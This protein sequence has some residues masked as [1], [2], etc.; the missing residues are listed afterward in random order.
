MSAFRELRGILAGLSIGLLVGWM[1]WGLEGPVRSGWAEGPRDTETLLVIV[2]DG[3]GSLDVVR[4]AVSSDRI[5]ASS[6]AGLAIAPQRLVVTALEAAGPLLTRAGWQDR[7]MEIFDLGRPLREAPA[8]DQR[9]A[10]IASLVS[11]PT[12]SRGEAYLL[13]GSL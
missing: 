7:P 10:R 11:K 4:R 2:V 5:L 8:G 12:L 6:Q 13:L 9:L 1:I 3:P